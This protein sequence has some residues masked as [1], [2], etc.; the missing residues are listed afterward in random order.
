M[1]WVVSGNIGQV[2]CIEWSL[3]HDLQGSHDRERGCSCPTNLRPLK[4]TSCQASRILLL[5]LF[6]HLLDKKGQTKGQPQKFQGKEL[7][8]FWANSDLLD[9]VII[10]L[11]KFIKSLRYPSLLQGELGM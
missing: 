3:G 1:W 8:L 10:Y 9:F 2:L 11:L 4:L 7:T 6:S 5:Q